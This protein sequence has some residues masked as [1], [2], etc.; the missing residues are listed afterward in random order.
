MKGV[1]GGQHIWSPSLSFTSRWLSELR[2]VVFS[3]VQFSHLRNGHHIIATAE[4]LGSG[5]GDGDF[6]A[7]GL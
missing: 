1:T 7:G 4:Y 2:Q 5:L 3:E 6:C